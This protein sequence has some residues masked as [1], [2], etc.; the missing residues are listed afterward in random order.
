MSLSSNHPLFL[1]QSHAVPPPIATLIQTETGR[2]FIRRMTRDVAERGRAVPDVV[3]QYTTTVR[4]MHIQYVEPMQAHAHIVL[5]ENEP[6]ET[7]D[8]ACIYAVTFHV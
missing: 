4:P 7:A 8:G 3:K 1:T 6:N 2:R 5:P